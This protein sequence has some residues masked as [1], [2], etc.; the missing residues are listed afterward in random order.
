M[1]KEG[2]ISRTNK[3]IMK[4][5]R[6]NQQLKNKPVV[7]IKSDV[8]SFLIR[9]PEIETKNIEQTL[10]SQE[11]QK[12][13]RQEQSIA[14]RTMVLNRKLA[15]VNPTPRD[16]K[17]IARIKRRL[18]KGFRPRSAPRYKNKLVRNPAR[19]RKCSKVYKLYI[20]SKFWTERKNQFYQKFLKMCVRCGSKK[21]IALHHKKYDKSLFGKE[22]DDHL[23]PMC[24]C[25]HQLFHKTYGTNPDMMVETDLFVN[26]LNHLSTTK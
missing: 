25:C 14:C 7:G 6:I 5:D 21:Y 24:G 3:N 8:F 15:L 26:E 12:Q 10:T 20:K 4:L 18:A 11:I 13:E 1:G 9:E 22:P 23:A 16:L 2:L 19:I 17:S